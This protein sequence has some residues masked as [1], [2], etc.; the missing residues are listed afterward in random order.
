VSHPLSKSLPYCAPLPDEQRAGVHARRRTTRSPQPRVPELDPAT[1][2]QAI[3]EGSVDAF[4]RVYRHYDAGVRYQLGKVALKAGC[5][6]DIEDLIQEV[7]SRL[8][9]DDRRLLRYYDRER[10]PFGSF[11][12]CIAVQQAWQVLHREHRKQLGDVS[13]KDLEELPDEAATA[14][15]AE[16]AQSDLFRRLLD[17]AD[18]RLSDHDRALLREHHI[19]GRTLRSLAEE[20]GVKELV[21]HKRNQRLKERLAALT[22]QLLA[23][24]PMARSSVSPRQRVTAAALVLAVLLAYPWRDDELSP[25]TTLI[26]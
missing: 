20:L 22:E 21:L 19:H 1:I 26:A 25:H 10:G 12:C 8:L 3:F 6:R 23:R 18:A 9:Y 16:L 11:L 17:E 4:I 7:W 13:S 2:Q 15:T 14:F 24:S 5:G